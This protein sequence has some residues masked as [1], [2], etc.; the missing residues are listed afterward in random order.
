MLPQASYGTW[1]Q[2]PHLQREGADQ[3]IPRPF[4][5]LRF[6]YSLTHNDCSLT[7]CKDN[8]PKYWGEKPF[9]QD[10][11]RRSGLRAGGTSQCLWPPEVPFSQSAEVIRHC[12]M[13][14]VLTTDVKGSPLKGCFSIAFN[15]NLHRR[16]TDVIIVFTLWLNSFCMSSFLRF[17]FSVLYDLYKELTCVFNFLEIVPQRAW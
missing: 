7:H 9:P 5:A 2:W 10:S 4:L 12:T 13:L 15:Y 16:L 11:G 8:Y 6:C 14:C 3:I 1:D 17:F